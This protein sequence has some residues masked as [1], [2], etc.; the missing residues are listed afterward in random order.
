[1]IDLKQGTLAGI[2]GPVYGPF[3]GLE[4]PLASL[5]VEIPPEALAD[6]E[7]SIGGTQGFGMMPAMDTLQEIII[8]A[9]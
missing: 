2:S 4:T 3:N 7:N 6:L 9:F 8:I 1:M 5:S